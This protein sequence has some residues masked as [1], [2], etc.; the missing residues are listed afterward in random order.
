[1]KSHKG[2]IRVE[3]YSD[4]RL[5]TIIKLLSSSGPRVARKVID[6][7]KTGC[8]F[9]VMRDRVCQCTAYKVGKC[10]QPDTYKS[11]EG[12]RWP[13][14]HNLWVKY[15]KGL[16]KPG[17]ETLKAASRVASSAGAIFAASA[18]RAFD[19]DNALGRCGDELLR[20]LRMGVQLALF[21]PRELRFGRYVRRPTIRRTLAM[22]E[23]TVDIDAIAAMVILLREAHESGDRD[24]SFVIGH[25]LHAALLMASITSHFAYLREE[26]FEFFIQRIFPMAFTDEI[27][28]ELDRGVMCEQAHLLQLTLCALTRKTLL[29]IKEGATKELRGLFHGDLGESLSYGLS[30]R[31]SLAKAPDVSSELAKQ[32]VLDNHLLVDWGIS[33]LREGRLEQAVP[34]E[35]WL[36]MRAAYI[37]MLK[38][39]F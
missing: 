12:D 6:V 25:S 30:P 22:L 10:V 17:S 16:R 29:V 27:A 26:L 4:D 9:E 32:S 2:L 5:K 1:M 35:L 37:H 3:D 23:R 38:R 33:M 36:P 28:F 15:A 20:S 21:D 39:L 7:L 18:W 14:H 11:K 24:K 8:W 13:Y 19:N 31:W 34:D